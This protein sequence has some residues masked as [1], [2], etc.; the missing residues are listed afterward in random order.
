MFAVT[1][2]PKRYLLSFLPIALVILTLAGCRSQAPEPPPTPAVA[3][4]ATA[5][6]QEAPTSAPATITTSPA[7]TAEVSAVRAKPTP[8]KVAGLGAASFARS[9]EGL[10]VIST[11]PRN[12][13]AG[14][15]I[16]GDGSRILVQF[17]RPVAPLTGVADSASLPSPLSLNPPAQGKGE[18]LN[19]STYVFRP[20]TLLP[21]T[22]Y[23][24]TVS[25]IQ[26]LVGTKLDAPVTFNFTTVY[27]GVD[28][29]GPVDNAKFVSATQPITVTF[30]QPMNQ[31]QTQAA[32]S[33]QPKG[34][35]P[36]AGAFS[37]SGSTMTFKPDQPLA[38]DT[39]Y[40]AQVAA[41]APD[42]QGKEK[43]AQDAAWSF[44]TAP[45][46]GLLGST[47]ADG[48]KSSRDALNGLQLSFASP[49]DGDALQVTVAPTITNQSIVWEDESNTKA[50]VYGGWQ[51]STPYTV[52]LGAG[53][54]TRDGEPLG[55]DVILRFSTAPL[56]PH[57]NLG[58][59]GQMAMYD[60]NRPPT[61]GAAV[62]NVKDLNFE[63]YTLPAADVLSF[64]GP[65]AYQQYE[66]FQPAASRRVRPTWTVTGNP[67][68][69]KSSVVTTTLT[70]DGKIAPGA[71]FLRVSSPQVKG[72]PDRHVLIVSDVNLLLK[73]TDS[74]ALVWATDL[75]TGQPV[76]GVPIVVYD[77]NHRP[78]GQGTT[79]ANGLVRVKFPKLSEPYLPIYALAERS[80]QVVG[81]VGGDW[82]DGINPFDYNLEG[83]LSQPDYLAYM[84]T[85]RPLY[86]PG[87]TAHF[88]GI[89]RGGRDGAY[90]IPKMSSVSITARDALGHEIL[91]TDVPLSPYGTFSGDIPLA[92]AAPLGYYSIS[93]EVPLPPTPSEPKPVF[94]SSTSFQVSEYRK[95]EFDVQVKTDKPSY[96]NGDV[97]NVTADSAYFFG[98]PVASGKM[99]WRL[100]ADDYF[101]TPPDSVKG[102]WDFADT[103]V[104]QDRKR[105][106]P[107]EVL[108]E[109][110]GTTDGQGQV[111]FK[112]SPGLGDVPISQNYTIE[113]EVTDI[114]GQS[115]TS[116]TVVPLHKG[117][118]Y[119][120]VAPEQYVGLAKQE[121]R[122]NLI[123]LDTQGVSVTNQALTVNVFRREW[124]TTRQKES[125]GQFYLTS[126]FSDTQ[127]ANLSATTDAQGKASVTY[128]PPQAGSYRI[129]AEGKD[130][131]GNTV[132]SAT[133]Q[134]IA[135]T[136]FVNWRRDDN[137]RMALTAD[138][139]TYLPGDT[140]RILVQSPFAPAEALVTV[141]RGDIRDVKRMTLPTTSTTIE[142]P[143]TKDDAPNVYVSV[144]AVK[145]GD[146]KTLPQFKLGN[147]RLDV[148]PR[149]KL[150]D[151]A[152]TPARP[153]A[154]QPGQTAIYN[155]VV[156]DSDGKPIQGEFSA[157][158][159][160]K[161]LYSLVDDTSK[162]PGD[163]FYATRPLGVGSAAT[164]IRNVN[165]VTAALA[166]G[167][168]GG[169]GGGLEVAPVRR[170]FQD[171]GY[172]KASFTTDEQGRAKLDIPLPDNL[173]TWTLTVV[174]V[175]PDTK[176]GRAR[177]DT[178]ATKDLLLRPTLPRFLVEGDN[179]RLGAVVQN[180]TD[181]P[182]DAQVTL[183]TQ[184]LDGKTD[185]ISVS[186]PARGKTLVGWDTRVGNV[187]KAGVMMAVDGGGLNDSIAIDIPVSRATTPETVGTAGVVTD[188]QRAEEV[189]RIPANAAPSQGS[190]SI[191]INPSVASVAQQGVS[192][193]QNY[194]WE[195]TE[196]VASRFL[197][198]AAVMTA[199]QAPGQ[200][201]DT[202]QVKAQLSNDLQKLYGQRN[203]D[204]GWGWW[205]GD[206]SNP[207]LTAY[208]L[209]ALYTG[210]QNGAAVD[211]NVLDGAA[212]YLRNYLDQRVDTSIPGM[213]SQ[214][215]F[216][217]W[218]LSEI[219]QPQ[220]GR[221][222]ELYNARNDMSLYGQAFL[223]MALQK[224]DAQ[225]QAPRIQALAQNLWAQAKR[226]ATGTHWEESTPNPL[227]MNTD[228]RTTA[229]ALEALGR[230]DPKD[231]N[232]PNVVTWLMGQ[233]QEDGAWRT[234]QETAWSTLALADYAAARGGGSGAS[235]F[236]VNLNGQDIKTGEVNSATTQAQKIEVALKDLAANAGNNLTIS[237]TGGP[238]MYYTE[239]LTT[240]SPAG[241]S[242][243]LDKGIVVGRTY[244]AVDPVTLKPTGQEAKDVKPGDYVMVKLTLIAPNA[245][246]HVVLEDPLPAGFEALDLS[247]KTTSAAARA[248]TVKQV[249]PAPGQPQP[250]KGYPGPDSPY[251]SYWTHSEVRDNKVAVFAPELRPGTYEYTYT[252]RASVPGQFTALP[253]TAYEMYSPETFGR[254]DAATFPIA[255]SE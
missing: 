98:G 73:R 126:V 122:I 241:Q 167:G 91:K 59:P 22:R 62:V 34:G 71:Y 10:K 106:R 146:D 240:Y 12:D 83:S 105:R 213:L 6:P 38:R 46:P 110:S 181:R 137:D 79:D 5:V 180:N 128:T 209:L 176:V 222:V 164:L 28:R 113:V 219:G 69:D 246:Y 182:I 54:K 66:K 33:L 168:K 8:G 124:Y 77:W 221:A 131:A 236:A 165:R 48:D 190:L 42:A 239:H 160:D 65:D 233:R 201:V 205:Q 7:P 36:V 3:A 103:D 67:P 248:P 72:T 29:T 75:K 153:G 108:S 140:A 70:T 210:Q 21:S 191:N 100:L 220:N 208:T 44:Q 161:A 198:T 192:Y 169:G 138:R 15:P 18:W 2:S 189:V 53:S 202:T 226:E 80:G 74:E 214:R 115:V 63:L 136:E 197:S 125:D 40:T 129:V 104:L 231:A 243:A 135:G 95:P 32:F 117:S 27:P 174:G 26:D 58:V 90:T 204:G 109:G 88:K 60:A 50:R 149:D 25:P 245:L 194:P 187:P 64:I 251:W 120:G 139:K 184:G 162:N 47:P 39:L 37:W 130:G 14:V 225:G 247:L 254:S 85:D 92:P 235:R 145:G 112:L 142:V 31:A 9:V 13:A 178:V 84:Y 19:T 155:I 242:Q 118:F 199:A 249:G 223:L 170:D 101:F 157:A 200:V 177:L 94:S 45:A 188:A 218:V 141:E 56:D 151:I 24:A 252:A 82:A 229:I 114:N 127:V 43:T 227:T 134:W 96:I 68:L 159:V 152:L 228:L 183:Q 147:V 173:T 81:A 30:N 76:D 230:V 87:Q 255:A 116:R 193:L 185:P 16:A 20:D 244:L 148:S 215:A 206:A 35:A 121:Q 51:P 216:V 133:Y 224:A 166:A 163:V 23:T 97:M 156:K 196:N 250:A 52:T 212:N 99:K 175:T 107:G 86:R 237:K 150:L 171:T 78:L 111:T 158:L 154:M 49:M 232:L 132:R 93:M 217:L 1:H 55:K 57:F 186:I 172:W 211:K 4:V 238:D 143:L 179:V 207:F 61:L 203:S 41:G 89:L 144:A 102:S 123:T 17:D 119:I 11:Q 234:P 195:A 253:A